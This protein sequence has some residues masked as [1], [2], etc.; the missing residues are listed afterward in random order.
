[1]ETRQ[2]T[3]DGCTNVQHARQMCGKHY[4][5]WRAEKNGNKQCARKSCTRLAVLDGLCRPHYVG[6]RRKEDD[7]D[8]RAARR[9]EVEGCDNPYDA[10]GYCELH[11]QRV[12]KNG[13]P[14]PA[15][16][17]RTSRGTGYL[18]V[19]T[20]YRS[21]WRGPDRKLEHRVVMEEHLGR[22]LR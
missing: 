22:S 10:M 19:K 7:A 12:R 18:H 16:R 1:M 14:G 11:Y 6:R 13:E 15:E 17:R 5:Q 20:G 4:Q 9:C 3:T 8:R 2:C 21:V